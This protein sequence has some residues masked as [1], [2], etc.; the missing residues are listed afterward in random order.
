MDEVRDTYF[1][2][3]PC[4][5][6]GECIEQFGY[7]AKTKGRDAM[8]DINIASSKWRSAR[9]NG[10]RRNAILISIFA[11]NV[12]LPDLSMLNMVSSIVT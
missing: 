11:N 2:H 12:F 7:E 10:S 9:Y 8:I 3:Y 5:E 4:Q 6:I 1:L